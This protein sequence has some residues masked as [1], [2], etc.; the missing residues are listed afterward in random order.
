MR[1][2]RFSVFKTNKVKD[3]EFPSVFQTHLGGIEILPVCGKTVPSKLKIGISSI[4]LKM[5]KT[6]RIY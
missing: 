3:Y 6:K 2:E 5:A 1:R 4:R